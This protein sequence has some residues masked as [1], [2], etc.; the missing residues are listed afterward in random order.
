MAVVGWLLGGCWEGNVS[1]AIVWCGVGRGDVS[2]FFFFFFFLL[3]EVGCV[4]YV[5][6]RVCVCEDYVTID[7]R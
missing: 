2:C 6:V 3:G 5:Y 4:L 1:V 7:V